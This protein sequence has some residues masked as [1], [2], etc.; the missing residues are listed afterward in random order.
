MKKTND[1]LRGN[2]LKADLLLSDYALAT[3]P[4]EKDFILKLLGA[5]IYNLDKKAIFL[6]SKICDSC[7][8]EKDLYI[9]IL[10]DYLSDLNA[11]NHNV[12][13]A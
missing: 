1:D 5:Y 10:M 4:E 9:E 7:D 6:Y 12:S 3:D 11:S 2:V 13:C 8:K